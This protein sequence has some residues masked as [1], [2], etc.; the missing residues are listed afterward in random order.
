MVFDCD[1]MAIV[2]SINGHEN[3]V[4]G[5]LRDCC[6]TG[7]I[8]VGPYAGDSAFLQARHGGCDHS[9]CARLTSLAGNDEWLVSIMGLRSCDSVITRVGA[10]TTEVVLGNMGGFARLLTDRKGPLPTIVGVA[11]DVTLN[12]GN[13]Y[14]TRG[15]DSAAIRMPGNVLLYHE[16]AGHALPLCMGTCDHHDPEPAAIAA[17]NLLRTTLGLPLREGHEGGR[18]AAAPGAARVGREALEGFAHEFRLPRFRGRR[19]YCVGGVVQ[20]S[21]S[22]ARSGA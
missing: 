6:P 7:R 3:T 8:D 11:I 16:L 5:F 20:R 2:I 1:I 17:E 18:I 14:W 15:A 19:Y 10:I 22:E 21:S 12:H 13:G 4:A 9:S